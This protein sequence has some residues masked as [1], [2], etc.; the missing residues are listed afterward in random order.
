MSKH[1]YFGSSVFFI[2]F[3]HMVAAMGTNIQTILV[4]GLTF[5]IAMCGMILN[6][7]Y[8]QR[9]RNTAFQDQAREHLE[10]ISFELQI[11]RDCRFDQ[12]QERARE[13][14]KTLEML[15]KLADAYE[16]KKP[17]QPEDTEGSQV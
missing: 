10:Q 6:E 16:Q 1:F 8:E 17:E 15:A 2:L 3:I 14:A 5:L 11:M 9:S 4:V 7:L 12:M 13:L